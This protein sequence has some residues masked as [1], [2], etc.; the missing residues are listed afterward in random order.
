MHLLA[1]H[2]D[3]KLIP[4]S[5]RFVRH[6]QRFVGVRLV[7]VK[8]TGADFA[9]ALGRLREGIPDL[10]LRSASQIKPTVRV[11]INFPVSQQFKVHV[12]FD[13]TQVVIIRPAIDQQ[14]ILHL[15]IGA[16]QFVCLG[17]HECQ[18]CG[19]HR[20][21]LGRTANQ[22]LPTREVFAV[23]QRRESFRL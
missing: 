14:P 3:A 10:N 11:R 9:P 18:I 17:L 19:G 6:G 15:P 20:R 7:I 23:E 8:T 1:C 2:H 5:H 22:P 4:L 21:A 16:S 12:V 13:R